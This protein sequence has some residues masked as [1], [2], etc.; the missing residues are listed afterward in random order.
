MSESDRSPLPDT[1]VAATGYVCQNFPEHP[2]EEPKMVSAGPGEG[3]RIC[4]ECGRMTGG[5]DDEIPYGDPP[6]HEPGL[7][8]TDN[9]HE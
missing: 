1:G 7:S 3:G 8:T 9:D 6:Y 5:P 2:G 4:P